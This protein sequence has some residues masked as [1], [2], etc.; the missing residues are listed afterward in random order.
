MYYTWHAK[1]TDLGPNVARNFH[2]GFYLAKG[3]CFIAI[4]DFDGTATL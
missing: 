3:P 4:P 1:M 2:H